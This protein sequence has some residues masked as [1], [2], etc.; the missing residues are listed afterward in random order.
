MRLCSLAE[1]ETVCACKP[2]REL[3][4]LVVP[5]ILLMLI[6]FKKPHFPLLFGAA[7]DVD[8]TAVAVSDAVGGAVCIIVRRCCGSTS[9]SLERSPSYVEIVIACLLPWRLKL[10]YCRLV[11]CEVKVSIAP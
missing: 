6:F 10:E 1:S 8:A 9:P 3:E 7:A 2:G 4:M 5:R 11:G